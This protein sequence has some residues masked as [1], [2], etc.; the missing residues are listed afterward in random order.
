MYYFDT[1]SYFEKTCF[2]Q[3]EPQICPCQNYY[4]T[5]LK[6]KRRAVTYLKLCVS[7][8]FSYKYSIICFFIFLTFISKIV[9]ERI[10]YIYFFRKYSSYHFHLFPSLKQWSHMYLKSR[11]INIVYY[12]QYTLLSYLT[13]GQ[14]PYL[15]SLYISYQLIVDKCK[16]LVSNRCTVEKDCWAL[17]RTAVFISWHFA[18]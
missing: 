18:D 15:T 14:E 3:F 16:I 4:M 13:K 1:F 12:I 10:V 2:L 5:I 9:L 6:S 8:S 17:T 11:Q 7:I